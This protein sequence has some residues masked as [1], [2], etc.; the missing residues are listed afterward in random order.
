MKV[1]LGHKQEGKQGRGKGSRGALGEGTLRTVGS[2]GPRGASFQPNG[3]VKGYAF[4]L[5]FRAA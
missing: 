4:V 2:L 3:P 5:V 1:E